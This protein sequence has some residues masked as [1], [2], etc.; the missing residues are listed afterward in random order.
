MRRPVEAGQALGEFMLIAPLLF[1]IFF[2]ILQLA[3]MGLST[4]AVQRAAMAIAREAAL[5]ADPTVSSLGNWRIVT[6]QLLAFHPLLSLRRRETLL[7][8]AGTRIDIDVEGRMVRATV[9]YPMPVWVPL[10]GPL[11]GGPIEMSVGAERLRVV[12]ETREGYER[13]RGIARAF[14]PDAAPLPEFPDP[15][16]TYARL[17]C[18]RMLTCAAAVPDENVVGEGK[19]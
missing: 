18:A 14:L 9:R 11:F 7:A 4:L 16:W 10:V 2:A 3:Y 1:L 13:L 12:R 6:Q 19:P 17:S 15:S 8:V 5:S